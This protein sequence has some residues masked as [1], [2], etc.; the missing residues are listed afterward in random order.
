MLR[1]LT[2]VLILNLALPVLGISC[3]GYNAY[4]NTQSVQHNKSFCTAFY[5]VA[6]G[7]GTFSG[8]DRDPVKTEKLKWDFNLGKDCQMQKHRLHEDEEFQI[9]YTC[10]CF[11]PMCNFPFSYKE[12]EARGFTLAPKPSKIDAIW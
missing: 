9:V 6:N 7:Q 12:F 1:F 10:F 2:I 5:E 8:A 4:S 3:Y 11:T